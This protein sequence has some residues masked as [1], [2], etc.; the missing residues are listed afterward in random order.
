MHLPA[1]VK[2]VVCY[3]YLKLRNRRFKKRCYIL[4]G[5]QRPL[6]NAPTCCT[7]Y[8]TY[9]HFHKHRITRW[10]VICCALHLYIES[11][12]SSLLLAWKVLRDFTQHPNVLLIRPYF[13][14]CWCL[15]ILFIKTDV[16]E[17]F[18]ASL[19]ANCILVVKT[20]TGHKTTI[21]KMAQ[22]QIV[23]NAIWKPEHIGKKSSSLVLLKRLS[24]KWFLFK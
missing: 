12:L 22:L 5:F 4:R 15:T 11:T 8:A 6:S 16:Y 2:S 18:H 3:R 21:L 13:W 24:L 17:T 23:L 20:S 19:Q 9:F 7:K 1:D 14:S 10:Q